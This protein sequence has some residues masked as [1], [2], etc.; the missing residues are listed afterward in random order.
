MAEW[1][2]QAAGRIYYTVADN[3]IGSGRY[4]SAGVVCTKDCS[5]SYS[6]AVPSSKQK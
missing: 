2:S 1:S 5:Y 4:I 3:S 6:C